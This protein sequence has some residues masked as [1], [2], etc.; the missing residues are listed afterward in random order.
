MAPCCCPAG[1]I[2]GLFTPAFNVATND[3]FHLLPPGA[4]PLS[5]YTALFWF[6]VTYVF[7][8][9]LV[10]SLM[11]R[12]PPKFLGQSC[13]SWAAWAKVGPPCLPVSY[14]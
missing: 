14:S 6:A 5:V 2:G 12:W 3:N 9:L 11:M 8:G 10:S 1:L 7:L 13:T 4:R